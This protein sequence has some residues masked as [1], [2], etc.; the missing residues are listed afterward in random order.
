MKL[1]ILSR[2][3]RNRIESGWRARSKLR[4]SGSPPCGG[5]FIY[6]VNF[7]SP[8]PIYK[9]SLFA[10]TFSATSQRA[11]TSS[12]D[13]RYTPLQGAYVRLRRTPGPKGAFGAQG[14][15]GPLG[16]IPELFQMESNF[17][18]SHFEWIFILFDNWLLLQVLLVFCTFYSFAHLRYSFSN[19]FR[20]DIGI[21]LR[22]SKLDNTRETREHM[23]YRNDTG[24]IRMWERSCE[25]FSRSTDQR[26]INVFSRA[27]RTP[28]QYYTK[29]T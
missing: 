3:N 6:K 13:A 26:R 7:C 2:T 28:K 23:C 24:A 14:P 18:L 16:V 29:H 10:T 8:V 25:R 19:V 9:P 15:K 4:F 11:H 5:I 21:D 20:F 12:T 17:E 27:L 22:A 1:S